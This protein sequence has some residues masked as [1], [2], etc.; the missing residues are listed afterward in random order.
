[1]SGWMAWLTRAN[2]IPTWCNTKNQGSV[3]KQMKY[4]RISFRCNG[5]VVKIY[6]TTS[7]QIMREAV[8]FE[9]VF[10]SS[11]SVRGPLFS[12]FII[13]VR[14]C[15]IPS[16]VIGKV[17]TVTL[18]TFIN[19]LFSSKFPFPILNINNVPIPNETIHASRDAKSKVFFVIQFWHLGGHAVIITFWVDNKM[20]WRNEQTFA[21]ISRMLNINCVISEV[22]FKWLRIWMLKYFMKRERKSVKANNKKPQKG[23]FRSRGSKQSMRN[24]TVLNKAPTS[25]IVFKVFSMISHLWLF[26]HESGLNSVRTQEYHVPDASAIPFHMLSMQFYIGNYKIASFKSILLH[27]SLNITWD[28]TN[29]DR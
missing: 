7:I 10:C 22:S 16:S 18:Y 25:D 27:L 8:W 29:F 15:N 9:W 6:A 2:V 28:Y 19:S 26:R 21:L 20:I 4:W 17:K 1:M 12:F 24:G 13:G 5:V 14:I 3:M 11:W 23:R